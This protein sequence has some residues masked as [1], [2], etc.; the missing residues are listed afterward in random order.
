MTL[1]MGGIKLTLMK[2][3][4]LNKKTYNT[5]EYIATGVYLVAILLAFYFNSSTYVWTAIATLLVWVF[6]WTLLFSDEKKKKNKN[7]TFNYLGY[8]GIILVLHSI[9]LVI[10]KF[11]NEI[12]N[13]YG[14]EIN[15]KFILI[16]F[17]VSGVVLNKSGFLD[18]E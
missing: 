11:S 3:I 12:P 7:V 16:S 18:D 5:I 13:I 14:F 17:L 1:F 4:I 10:I 15:G 9:Y 2:K 6:I 8:L